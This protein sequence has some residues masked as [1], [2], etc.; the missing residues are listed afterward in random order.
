MKG[1]CRMVIVLGFIAYVVV[2]LFLWGL[3]AG[4]CWNSKADEDTEQ[5]Q[6]LCDYNRRQGKN[7]F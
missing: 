5:G 6:W 3:C 1:D 2:F 7:V 4:G